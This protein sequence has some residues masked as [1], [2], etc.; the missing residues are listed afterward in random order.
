M[1]AQFRFIGAISPNYEVAIR[2]CGVFLL[3]YIIFGGYFM[4]LE[5]LMDIAPWFGWIAVG[6]CFNLRNIF[7]KF[8][9]VCASNNLRLRSNDGKRVPWSLVGMLAR[10]RDSSRSWIQ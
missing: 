1:T 9:A 2:Y 7:A 5:D 8:S 3:I 6:S 10:I 4:S